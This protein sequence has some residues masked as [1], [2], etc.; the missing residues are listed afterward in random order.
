V[1]GDIG[2]IGRTPTNVPETLASVYADYTIPTGWT[3]ASN[4]TRSGTVR[5]LDTSAKERPT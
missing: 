2:T 5:V 4:S 3:T 1:R